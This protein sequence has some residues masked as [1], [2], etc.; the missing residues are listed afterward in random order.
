MLVCGQMNKTL[1]NYIKYKIKIFK[2]LKITISDEELEHMKSLKNDRD[3][4]RYARDL[5]VK[6][7]RD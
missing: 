3:I 7:R 1:E 4:D 2:E 5:I 6:S